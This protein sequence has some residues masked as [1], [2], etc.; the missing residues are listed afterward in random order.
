MLGSLPSRASQ[1]RNDH[2]QDSRQDS[3]GRCFYKKTVGLPGSRW[4]GG[5]LVRTGAAMTQPESG[6]D[7][8][9]TPNRAK[10]YGTGLLYSVQHSRTLCKGLS[11]L[12]CQT[13]YWQIAAAVW[14]VQV[15]RVSP[16]LPDLHQISVQYSRDEDLVFHVHFHAASIMLRRLRFLFSTTSPDRPRT[17]KTLATPCDG[18]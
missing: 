7:E 16:L 6:L 8:N 14:T 5:W 4:V 15:F 13:C 2:N 3:R 17:E 1:H 18:E 11:S 9:D 12:S 10:V